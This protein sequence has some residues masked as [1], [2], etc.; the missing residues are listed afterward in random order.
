MTDG[1]GTRRTLDSFCGWRESESGSQEMVKGWSSG[2]E[3]PKHP[4]A[5]LY[6]ALQKWKRVTRWIRRAACARHPCY[7]FRV[8][9]P[10]EG[11]LQYVAEWRRVTSCVQAKFFSPSFAGWSADLHS[12][13]VRSG[14]PVSYG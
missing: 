5:A 10:Q 4:V 2:E 12:R 8:P 9:P 3:H 13:R 7:S 1:S 14:D 11:L 6:L